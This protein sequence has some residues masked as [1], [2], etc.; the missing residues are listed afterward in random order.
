VVNKDFGNYFIDSVAK[1]YGPQILEG[2]GIANF[3]N[4]SNESFR[5]SGVKETRIK[6]IFHKK[7]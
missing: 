4:E 1:A 2:G 5:D 7:V 6:G 3:R